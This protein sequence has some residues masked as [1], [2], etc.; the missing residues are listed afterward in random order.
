M[1]VGIGK[2]Y[3]LTLLKRVVLI[4][5]IAEMDKLAEHHVSTSAT[6]YIEVCKIFEHATRLEI[7]FWDMGLKLL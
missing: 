5:F 1:T 3:C 6:R 2:T 7:A 4:L